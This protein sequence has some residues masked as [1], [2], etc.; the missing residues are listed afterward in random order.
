MTA[1]FA[2]TVE[3]LQ[4]TTGLKPESGYSAGFLFDFL[5]NPGYGGDRLGQIWGHLYSP[6]SIRSAKTQPTGIPPRRVY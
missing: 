4:Q 1:M 3:V 5:F 2:K 6:L